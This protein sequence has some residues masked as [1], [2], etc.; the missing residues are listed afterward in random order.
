MG[1]PAYFRWISEKYPR[2]LVNCIEYVDIDADGAERPIDASAPNPNGEFDNL[3]LDMNGIIH[4]CTHPEDRPP[5][6]TELEMFDA[7]FDYIDR[8]FSIV[9]PRKL[10]YMA[11][12]GVAPRAKIN[13]QRSRRFR[14]AKEAQEKMN[15]A[16]EL[17]EEWKKMG[18]ELDDPEDPDADAA[19]SHLPF[20]SNVI[21][22][23]TPF[24]ARLAVALRQYVD[25][26]IANDPA[27]TNVA[28]I[29]SDASVPGE[30]EHKIAEYIRRE[31]AE[32]DYDPNLKHVM[33][34]LDADLIMLA[35]ATHEVHFTIL[36]EEVFQKRGAQR[37]SHGRDPAAQANDNAQRQSGDAALAQIHAQALVQGFN[38]RDRVGG[39]KPFHFLHV[40][41]LREYLDYEFRA[42][43]EMEISYS[44]LSAEIGYDLERVLDDFVFLCFFVGND[45]LPHLPSLDIRDG[46][47]DYLIELYKTQLP[48][49]GYL[50]SAQGHVDFVRVRKLMT[51]VG[52]KENAIWKE[53]K[54]REQQMA[55][56][57]ARDK[58]Q[59][60]EA[61]KQQATDEKL[62][63]PNQS[64]SPKSPTSLK[65]SNPDKFRGYREAALNMPMVELG[66]KEQPKIGSGEVYAA[67]KA[68]LE[69]KG[70]GE[71]GRS[72]SLMKKRRVERPEGK[73]E[74]LLKKKTSTV[75]SLKSS[76]SPLPVVRKTKSEFNEA[77]NQRVREK[78][79]LVVVDNIKLGEHGWKDRYYKEKFGW[80]PSDISPKK[81]LFQKY[82]E[83]LQWVM[84]YYYVG[85]M[86]WGWYYPY[87]YAPF[88]S[89]LVESDVDGEDIA[90]ELGKPFEPFTQLQA[91][92]PASSGKLVLPKCYSD[93]MVD[94]ASPIIDYYPEKFELDLNGKRFAWQ[95][96]A[97]LP[98]ID[99]TRLNA[100]IEPLKDLL[101]EEEKERNSF[102]ETCIMLHKDT[103]LGKLRSKKES[104]DGS[105][106]KRIPV[107]AAWGQLFGK[108]SFPLT[109]YG[110]TKG[111]VYTLIFNLPK[112]KPHNSQL[113]P[114]AVVPPPA[115]NDATRADSKRLG[116]KQAKFGPLGKA[117]RDLVIDRNRRLGYGSGKGN[118]P[119]SRSGSMQRTGYLPDAPVINRPSMPPNAGVSD[120]FGGLGAQTQR[121]RQ[122]PNWMRGSRNS[123]R[124]GQ[125]QAQ[126]RPQPAQRNYFPQQQQPLRNVPQQPRNTQQQQ[127]NAPQSQQ[128]Q[129]QALPQVYN[130]AYRDPSEYGGYYAMGMQQSQQP[131]NGMQQ[132][133]SPGWQ[134]AGH[135]QGGWG[136]GMTS[137]AY[138]GY[139]MA[140]YQP[141]G[142]GGGGYYGAYDSQ[143]GGEV[144]N[145][146]QRSGGLAGPTAGSMR[147]HPNQ[148]GRDQN[149][150]RRQH[151]S[152][153]GGWGGAGY[154]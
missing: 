104:E 45:F 19:A 113:L 57:A 23:G 97:L 49:I 96:V 98:F 30:G 126:S 107:E 18:L 99:E 89:D 61:A 33:Y 88:A 142:G 100:A 79:E 42:D 2:I 44:K 141:D 131:W 46:A 81:T 31:R 145:G 71:D 151:G 41:T 94:P 60:E 140:P 93:L 144:G 51:L 67:A 85:C 75:E 122:Q 8:I 132:N 118:R 106:L 9:R 153:Y 63:P 136:S 53:R 65:R 64:K 21:T 130:D 121:P 115:L 82:I 111:A 38:T 105:D 102:G 59:R 146:A 148:D 73:M 13:Q 48:K 1:I 66:R 117:A 101:T 112:F 119:K 76:N 108:A 22:P 47:I 77:L 128:V 12:D 50:T 78:N 123:Y 135:M 56:R 62:L 80:A 86:S 70:G 152:N 125:H 54:Q 17:K 14:S 7:I 32:V 72:G 68:A 36:R 95:G 10:L 154:R 5:P 74:D 87:H 137:N 3:Y 92:M 147:H 129:M 149:Q 103:P 133:P 109:K 11:I 91:V 52:Q 20:D 40:H 35:L 90:F 27:W 124:G 43:I 116:W 25:K 28:V 58:R 16:N 120:M 4:P 6:E 15:I 127:R 143:A 138:S 83:G 84:T 114:A 39:K 110:G 55:E 150:E 29:F 37:H 26:R 34:G 69:G 24:M 134:S 139:E